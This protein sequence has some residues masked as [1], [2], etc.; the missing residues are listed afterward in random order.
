MKAKEEL[1]MIH[2][3]KARGGMGI[4]PPQVTASLAGGL[5]TQQN[6]ETCS[7]NSGCRASGSI[8]WQLRQ[9]QRP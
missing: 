6:V 2:T 8:D 9:Y 3:L 5:R 1:P 7:C 4:A